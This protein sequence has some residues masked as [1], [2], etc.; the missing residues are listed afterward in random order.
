M[1]YS[2]GLLKDAFLFFV[3]F[4]FL[5]WYLE[6]RYLCQC[7]CGQLQYYLLLAEIFCSVGVFLRNFI[8]FVNFIVSLSMFSFL[9]L[10]SPL[11]HLIYVSFLY[12]WLCHGYSIK[13][14]SLQMCVRKVEHI[15]YCLDLTIQLK[16]RLLLI[17]IYFCHFTSKKSFVEFSLTRISPRIIIQGY[18]SGKGIVFL[19]SRILCQFYQLYILIIKGLFHLIYISFLHFRLYYRYSMEQKN[20]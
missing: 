10:I 12:V 17:V 16:W 14:Q 13:Q 7:Y 6:W 11:F 2:N 15:D 8:S 18:H 19:T 9:I 4:T 20:P 1:R 3:I 5:H